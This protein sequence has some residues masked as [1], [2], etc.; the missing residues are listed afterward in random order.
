VVALNVALHDF[1]AMQN[2]QK[3]QMQKA[4]A[5]QQQGAEAALLHLTEKR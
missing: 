2:Q 4:M 3:L 5:Q 1:Q